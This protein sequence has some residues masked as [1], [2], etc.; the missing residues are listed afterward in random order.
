[1]RPPVE[2]V[3]QWRAS[4]SGERPP[5]EGFKCVPPVEW[6]I[7]VPQWRGLIFFSYSDLCLFL[8]KLKCFFQ[9][10]PYSIQITHHHNRPFE[11]AINDD[12]HR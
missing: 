6:L 12:H 5:V 10:H 9:N 1:M 4:P 2:S 3:P 11:N 7:C 8:K